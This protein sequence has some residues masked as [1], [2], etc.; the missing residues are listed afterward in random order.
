MLENETAI[1]NT[2]EPVWPASHATGLPSEPRAGAADDR[3][4]RCVR[5]GCR[6]RNERARVHAV[7]AKRWT[8]EP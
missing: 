7:A 4:S 1:P 8:N 6:A 5:P 3:C 2:R